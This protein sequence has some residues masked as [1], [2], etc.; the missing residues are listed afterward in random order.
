MGYIQ[1]GREAGAE[2]L[3]GGGRVGKRGNFIEPTVFTDVKNQMKIDC[4]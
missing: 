2:M 3:T 4:E 1:A